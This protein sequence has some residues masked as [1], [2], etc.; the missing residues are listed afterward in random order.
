MANVRIDANGVPKGAVF[1]QTAPVAHRLGVTEPD[2]GD[3]LSP[4][5]GV[6][7]AGYEFVDFDLDVTLGGDGPLVEVAPLYFDAAA[8]AWFRGQSHFIAESGRTRLRVEARGATVY[9]AV[10]ALEGEEATL[11]LDAWASLS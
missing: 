2:E 8:E 5:D 1:E 6:D 4:A 10:L 3:P 7:A 11:D 9:L